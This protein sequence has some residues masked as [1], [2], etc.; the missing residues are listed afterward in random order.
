MKR[1]VKG[2]VLLLLAVILGAC[3]GKQD[4]EDVKE[5]E[6]EEVEQEEVEEVRDVIDER[7]DELG[8]LE[9]TYDESN[10]G[11]I[12]TSGD[13]ELRV[14]EVEVA[15]LDLVEEYQQQ[16]GQE[17]LT[18]VRLGVEVENKGTEVNKFYPD[19]A[20]LETE[21]GSQTSAD[22]VYTGDVGGTFKEGDMKEGDIVFLLD[23]G[24]AN[25]ESFTIDV[26]GTVVEGDV[27]SEEEID[28]TIILG[29]I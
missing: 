19:Q 4:T 13:M 11:E 16:Y 24:E 26:Y 2:L 14:K 29:E 8:K 22:L 25:M 23:D 21:S 9:I 12:G 10:I 5:E 28:L 7:E 3:G 6:K 1:V 18:Y 27:G 17:K 20:G 15:A